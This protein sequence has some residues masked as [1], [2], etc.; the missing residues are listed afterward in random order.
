MQLTNAYYNSQKH[1]ATLYPNIPTGPKDARKSCTWHVT[2][3][4]CLGPGIIPNSS[5][6][7]IAA[8]MGNEVSAYP[9]DPM[10]S[11]ILMQNMMQW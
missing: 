4:P 7:G 9:I 5:S 8:G 11:Q 3:F 10:I 1:Y 6:N 2:V